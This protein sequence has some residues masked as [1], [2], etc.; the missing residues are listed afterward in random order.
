MRGSHSTRTGVTERSQIAVDGQVDMAVKTSGGWEGEVFEQNRLGTCGAC[1][2]VGMGARL[3][4]FIVD[5]V[6]GKQFVRSYVGEG[7]ACT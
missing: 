1:R 5:T 7:S 2:G 3:Q 4:R 6:R